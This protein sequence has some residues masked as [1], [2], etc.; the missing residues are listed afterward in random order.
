MFGNKK[1]P[2]PRGG[3]V[4]YFLNTEN[5]SPTGCSFPAMIHSKLPAFSALGIQTK[6]ILPPD[7]LRKDPRPFPVFIPLEQEVERKPSNG[8]GKYLVQ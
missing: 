8:H 5:H 3:A 6:E 4:I 7:R 2:E 1:N